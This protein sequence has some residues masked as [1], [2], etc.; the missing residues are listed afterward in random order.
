MN[1]ADG[2]KLLEAL[3]EQRMTFSEF[4]AKFKELPRPEQ[5]R[6]LQP[7]AKTANAKTAS[8]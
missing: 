7:K 6:L 8:V 4:L 3:S 5:D 1:N 2:L